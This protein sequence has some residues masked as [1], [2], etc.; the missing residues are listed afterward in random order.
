MGANFVD[1]VLDGVVLNA[2][3]EE[4]VSVSMAGG[5]EA[6]VGQPFGNGDQLICFEPSTNLSVFT[7]EPPLINPESSDTL[8]SAHVEC[9]SRYQWL[10][11]RAPELVNSP[12]ALTMQA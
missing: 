2:H 11:V 5:V 7:N 9:F 6:H 1:H 8:D 3:F 10:V 12:H 4:S